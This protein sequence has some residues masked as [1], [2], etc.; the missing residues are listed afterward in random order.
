MRL[1]PSKFKPTLGFSHF[2]HIFLK[3]L[4]PILVYV[5][6]RIDFV[7]LAIAIILLSKWRIFVVRPRYWGANILSNGVD[8]LV[9][10]S[11]TLFMAN[12]LEQWWQIF[13]TLSYAVWLVILK[14]RSDVLA[15]SVQ[16]MIG[17][18]LALSALYLKFGDAPLSLLILGT[19]LVAYICGKHFFSSF[20]E[21][22]TSLMSDVWAYFAAGLAFVLGHWLLF[23]GTLAQIVLLL[24]TI[25]YSLAAL[26]YL[27]INE[28]L[29]P[30]LQRQLL[31]I[32]GA[33]LVVI[34]ILSD[35]TGVTV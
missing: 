16:A 8:I 10:V 25:G 15:V 9:G 11:L 19:W 4:L 28:R 3:V 29:T 13:W 35:W 20:S 27:H 12:T 6:V 33:I 17:Q 30:R 21:S 22:H 34:V 1:I 5:L 7:W 2:L 31:G 18:L 14:P 23:Y 24:T 32:T 26:Y